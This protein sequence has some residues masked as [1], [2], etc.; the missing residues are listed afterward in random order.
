MSFPYRKTHEIHTFRNYTGAQTD[1][2]VSLYNTLKN[3]PLNIFHLS[4]PSI[5]F[6]FFLNLIWPRFST[7]AKAAE[8][9]RKGIT[10]FRNTDDRK[11]LFKNKC[12][13]KKITFCNFMRHQ[14]W[15]LLGEIQAK[16]QYGFEETQK[17]WGFLRFNNICNKMKLSSE[18]LSTS[19]ENNNHHP[20][21]PE[22]IVSTMCSFFKEKIDIAHLKYLTLFC[23]RGK[24]V[25][26]K[27]K[28]SSW[29]FWR[30]YQR[31]LWKE[32]EFSSIQSS[33]K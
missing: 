4:W 10:V 22:C 23:K 18:V 11:Y 31:I 3:M 1:T 30:C 12:L 32:R 6:L 33:Q 5:L 28:L 26:T 27:K 25:I 13:L 2:T 21:Q 24:G 7:E 9:F 20:G 17:I 15:L 19:W 14:R 29:V 8:E 16:R